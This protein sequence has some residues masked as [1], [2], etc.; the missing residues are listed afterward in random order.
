MPHVFWP[1]FFTKIRQSC[2][3][4]SQNQVGGV[5]FTLTESLGFATE[6]SGSEFRR[7]LG[8]WGRFGLYFDQKLQWFVKSSSST[9]VQILQF[10]KCVLPKVNPGGGSGPSCTDDFS[11][12]HLCQY[13]VVT[14]RCQHHIC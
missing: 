2:A 5:G 14:G 10:R 3:P 4:K 6:N 13:F 1:V 9:D 12:L 11:G 7:S 8:L